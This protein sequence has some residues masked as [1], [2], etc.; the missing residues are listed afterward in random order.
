MPG[1]LP[2]HKRQIRRRWTRERLLELRGSLDCTQEELARRA[3]VS[4]STVSR[5]ER[6]RC[7]PRNAAVISRLERLERLV[8]RRRKKGE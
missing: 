3:G 1:M 2:G 4:V 7:L 5:W 8:R 6:G